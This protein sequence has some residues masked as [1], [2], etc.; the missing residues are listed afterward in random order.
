MMIYLTG[1]SIP[2]ITSDWRNFQPE[3]AK[4]LGGYIS[5]SPF[6]N[7]SIDKVFDSISALSVS[8]NKKET[9]AFGLI[10]R[11]KLEVATDV[12][13][14]IISNEALCKFN[15]AAVALTDD[16][17]MEHISSKDEEPIQASF[18]NADFKRA[19]VLVTILTPGAVGEEFYFSPFNVSGIITQTGL[20]GTILA[21]QSAFDSNSDYNF[22]K[23][24]EKSFKIVKND[25]ESVAETSCSMI[26]SE[27]VLSVSFGS[28]FKNP[29]DNRRKISNALLYNQGVGIWIQRVIDENT[30]RTNEQLVDDYLNNRQLENKE[31]IEIYFEYTPVPLNNYNPEQYNPEQYS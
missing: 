30:R 25:H 1:A 23:I 27:D 18:Y 2:P 9:L 12:Y 5:G 7:A 28:G 14:K 21:I 17:L 6:P 31:E 13:V 19:E 16:L 8:S 4:S 15:I 3:V 20:D 22:V 29:I 11:Q 24:D 26:A 10:N